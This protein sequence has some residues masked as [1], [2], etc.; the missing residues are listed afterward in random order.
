[1]KCKWLQNQVRC[2]MRTVEPILSYKPQNYMKNYAS[3][4]WIEDLNSFHYYKTNI[5]HENHLRFAS[6]L[7]EI[8]NKLSNHYETEIKLRDKEAGNVQS[9]M[10][11]LFLCDS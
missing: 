9:S 11:A 10:L 4:C 3:P 7:R 6:K 8:K 5:W 1:M 2:S